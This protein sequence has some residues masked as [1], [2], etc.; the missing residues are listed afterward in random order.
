MITCEACG[1][2]APEGTDFIETGVV[3]TYRLTKNPKRGN[4]VIVTAD[5]DCSLENN[6][7]IM[8]SCPCGEENDVA[9]ELWDLATLEDPAPSTD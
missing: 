4:A 6:H 9:A 8:W 5:V 1:K 7:S 3:T 2:A